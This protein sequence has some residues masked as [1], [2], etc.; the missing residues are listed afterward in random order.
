[1]LNSG[2]EDKRIFERFPTG[3]PVR[4]LDLNENREGEAQSMDISA[5]GIGLVA[6]KELAPRTPLE[7]WLDIPDKGEPFYTRGEVV[8]S[9]MIGDSR[10]QLGVNLE[11]ANLMGLS[12][13]MRAM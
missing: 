13:V 10:C 11:K 1:M 6:N 2:F 9:K 7:L 8:W 5:K 12:R 3:F 4:F